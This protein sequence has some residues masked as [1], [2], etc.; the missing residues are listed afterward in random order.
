MAGDPDVGIQVGDHGERIQGKCRS[1]PEKSTTSLC[2][3][4]NSP[5]APPQHQI[6]ALKLALPDRSDFP[7]HSPQLPFVP[8]VVRYIS[9][10]LLGPELSVG[11]GSRGRLASLVPMPETSMDE[12]DRPVLGQDDVRLSWK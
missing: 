7:P 5:F 3:T 4:A 1:G 6:R 9:S 11:L 10:E 2:E 8:F 12:D